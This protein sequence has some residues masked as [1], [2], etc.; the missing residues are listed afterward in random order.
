MTTGKLLLARVLLGR[1]DAA[2]LRRAVE[3][4]EDLFFPERRDRLIYEA[5]LAIDDPEID[6]VNLA[7]QLRATGRLEEVGSVPYLIGLAEDLP[8]PGRSVPRAAD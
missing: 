3:G 5:M 8:G 6:L 2:I 1:T 7:E 4:D